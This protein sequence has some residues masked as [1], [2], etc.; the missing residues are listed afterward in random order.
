[1]KLTFEQVLAS[2]P[3]WLSNYVTWATSFV[4]SGPVWIPAYIRR[5]PLRLAGVYVR[6]EVSR[7][8]RGYGGYAP[9][10]KP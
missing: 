8:N 6:V 5:L 7:L 9:H 10:D 2:M 3:P 1:M 4:L